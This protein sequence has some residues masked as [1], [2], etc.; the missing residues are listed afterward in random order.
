[1]NRYEDEDYVSELT[2]RIFL[3]KQ[4]IERG[5]VRISSHLIEGVRESLS[6]V[7]VRMDGKIDPSTVD[8]RLK[9]MTVAVD[10]FIE[11]ERIKNKYSIIELQEQYFK[12][13]FTNFDFLYKEMERNS[14]EPYQV[15][16]ASSLDDNF[17]TH[18]YDIFPEMYED[19]KSFWDTSAEVGLIHLQEGSQLKANFSG[20]LFPSYSENAVSISGLYI[21][22]V[23]LPCPILRI[24]RLHN[25]L[26]KIEFCKLLIKH[27][28]TCMSYRDVALEETIPPIALILP[29]KSDFLDSE[30]EQ[31]KTDCTPYVLAHAQYLY[32]KKFE[33]IEDFKN[34][35]ES[36]TNI[37]MLLKE[38]KRPDRLIFDIEWGADPQTQLKR[39]FEDR[40][41]PTIQYFGDHPGLE[42]FMTCAGRM[43]QALAAK[44]NAT[45]RGSTP[46][47]N[48]NTS[49]LYYTWLI[50]Y[51]SMDFSIDK[52]ELK[53]LHMVHAISS[54]MDDGFSWLG[55]IPVSK[56]IELRRNNVMPELREILSNGVEDMIK[57]SPD[58]Y[59]KTSQQV[60]DNVDN[61]FRVHKNYL[62]KAK[63]EKLRI[64]GLEVAPC[65]VSGTI[66]IAA[67]ATNH[68]VLT[69]ATAAASMMG[70]PTFK[71]VK[72]KFKIREDKLQAYNKS[73]TGILFSSFKN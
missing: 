56:I 44:N 5:K 34:F 23:T 72:S 46:Y 57:T 19:I 59:L 20:D 54:G 66:A 35:S 2:D 15:A 68:P 49:W 32:D 31:L 60:I 53:N 40:S 39:L 52:E 55:N 22:T 18:L 28:L 26:S 45:S 25:S 10:H 3:L 64:F 29:E 17:T 48:A 73:A 65:I 42:T 61:S 16:I 11:R 6:K 27:I 13:L 24:G 51:E 47:M 43:P 69:Y 71:D 37:D 70:I 1:M 38:L 67:A 33:G 58:N 9:S 21:D 30:T 8:G 4:E 62:R 12:I 41:R 36:L 50:E 7:R 14:L 63:Q